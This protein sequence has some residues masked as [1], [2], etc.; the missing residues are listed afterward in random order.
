MQAFT[1]YSMMSVL[2]P[3]N[4][5]ESSFFVSFALRDTNSKI[6]EKNDKTDETDKIEWLLLI[7]HFKDELQQK[8][9]TNK[10]CP[11]IG[12]STRERALSKSQNKDF[13]RYR[14]Q[15][16]EMGGPVGARNKPPEMTERMLLPKH[17]DNQLSGIRA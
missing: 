12:L 3:Q 11:W 7:Y 16:N 5:I 6:N 8:Y 2:N 4:L 14:I 9:G 1:F 10:T 13:F 15:Q 17:G